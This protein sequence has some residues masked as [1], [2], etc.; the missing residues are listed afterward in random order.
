[1][2]I[3]SISTENYYSKTIL[4]LWVFKWRFSASPLK[5]TIKTILLLWDNEIWSLSMDAFVS[6]RYKRRGLIPWFIIATVYTYINRLITRFS[7]SLALHCEQV[8]FVK[9]AASLLPPF[10][11]FLNHDDTGAACFFC[12]DTTTTKRTTTISS[13]C[14]ESTIQCRSSLLG[15]TFVCGHIL[16]SRWSVGSIVV[17]VVTL[18]VSNIP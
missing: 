10:F 2:E 12:I 9:L 5:I 4:L 14:F 1:M 11:L 15:G 18:S 8:G 17:V 3:F 6:C 16:Y 13:L 7:F